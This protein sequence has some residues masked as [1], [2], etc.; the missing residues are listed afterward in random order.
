M[1]AAARARAKQA[2]KDNA[3]KISARATARR[4]KVKTSEANKKVLRVLS[5]IGAPRVLMQAVSAMA[6][7]RALGGPQRVQLDSL[8]L[9]AGKKAYTRAVLKD[10][11]VAV[12]LELNDALPEMPEMM[13]FMTPSG[14]ALAMQLSLQL[15]RGSQ[16][17][18]APV[19]SS[20]VWISRGTTGPG[21]RT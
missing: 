5:H 1:P 6:R 15:K 4:T 8:E 2:L 12:G 16:A 13:D 14:F 17:V 11:R 3:C 7:S 10:G 18:A 20:W 19:C 9:F 21:Y